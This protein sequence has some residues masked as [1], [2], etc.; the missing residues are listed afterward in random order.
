MAAVHL[1]FYQGWRRLRFAS[2]CS[3]HSLTDMPNMLPPVSFL[4]EP[5]VPLRFIFLFHFGR[6]LCST[7]FEPFPPLRPNP[8]SHIGQISCPASIEPSLSAAE[9]FFPLPSNI[10]LS[11]A[12]EPFGRLQSYIFVPLW[13]MNFP[14]PLRPNLE[15][16][17]RYLGAWNPPL[18]GRKGWHQGEERGV[19]RQ[20]GRRGVKERHQG[21]ESAHA[22]GG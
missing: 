16:V 3:V 6:T 2:L 21:Q 9:Q 10:C 22:D 18:S 19:E 5:F 13:R 14:F 11:T 12:A 1:L 17:A 15:A 20:A 4:L 7:S 8:L